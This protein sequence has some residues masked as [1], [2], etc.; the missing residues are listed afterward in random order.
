MLRKSLP[1]DAIAQYT[2]IVDTA[3]Y[4]RCVMGSKQIQ[5][6]SNRAVHTGTRCQ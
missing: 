6:Q 4:S 1:G 5:L 3:V 2:C